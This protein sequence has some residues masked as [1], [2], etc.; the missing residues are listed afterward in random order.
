M[1]EDALNCEGDVDGDGED[2]THNLLQTVIEDSVTTHRRTAHAGRRVL[3]HRGGG[4]ISGGKKR[5][6][7]GG[8]DMRAHEQ[9]LVV[10]V[11]QGMLVSFAVGTRQLPMVPCVC[12]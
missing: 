10:I 2:M 12:A 8:G 3:T 9:R 5:R 11:L 6:R 4:S 7:E 1:F